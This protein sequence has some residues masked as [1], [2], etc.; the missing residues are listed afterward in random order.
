MEKNAVVKEL[1]K[2]FSKRDEVVFS[3]L[4]GSWAK[5]AGG[6]ESDWDIAVYYKSIK[7]HD[8]FEKGVE[9]PIWIDVENIVGRNVDLLNLNKAFPG[10]AESALKGIPLVIKDR[11]VYM[12]Y[13]L[14]ITSEA[15]DLREWI[16]SYWDLKQG[17]K[18]ATAS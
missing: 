15:D 6:L 1:K 10:V 5:G 16:K 18:H 7:P 2:Y 17:R 12:G 8:D 13:L 14:R 9:H 11:N 3:F 4:F